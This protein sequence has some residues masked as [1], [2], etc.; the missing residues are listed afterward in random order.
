[1]KW[2][3]AQY[4]E[5]QRNFFGKAGISWHL[6]HV[7]R[8]VTLSPSSTSASSTST[9]SS[10]TSSSPPTFEHRTLCHVFDSCT[11][12]G[13]C[14]ISILQHTISQLKKTMPN[15]NRVYLRSDNAGC[16]HGAATLLAVRPLYESTGV[17]VCR[18][19]FSEPQAGK[20][21]CDRSAAT[22]KGTVRR[23][24]NE[25]HDCTNSTEFVTAASSTRHLSLFSS[26]I[27]RPPASSSK[28]TT[29]KPSWPGIRSINNVEYAV[30]E[31]E[32]D[33]D[34]QVY[35]S[36][37]ARAWKAFGVGGG[38]ELQLDDFEQQPIVPLREEQAKH[39]NDTWKAAKDEP[40]GW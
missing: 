29:K 12:D 18:I 23:H 34:G 14:V 26:T 24:M 28:S 7:V 32:D 6:A 11:Q 37:S 35:D 19:D 33:D 25:R 2:L 13:P 3:P 21:P 15:L 5:H 22:I 36:F 38:K 4:R 30:E 9:S 8:R 1:M 39:V 27:P 17:L 31:R 16:Y 20:G 10:S 40:E